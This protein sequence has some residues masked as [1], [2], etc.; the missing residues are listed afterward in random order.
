MT[1]PIPR[2]RRLLTLIPLIRRSPGIT[3]DQ[4]A[5]LLKVSRKEINADLVRLNLCGVPP[6]LP[7]DYISVLIDGD[8]ISIDYAE[9]FEKPAALTLREALALKLALEALPPG[10]ARINEARGELMAAVDRL[11]RE[12]GSEISLEL[13]G[14]LAQTT[15]DATTRKLTQLREAVKK[16]RPLDVV[17]YSASS[18]NTAPRRLRPLG[19]AESEGN[20]Y[21]VALDEGKGDLRHFRVDRIASIVEPKGAGAFEPPADFDLGAFM[22]KGFGPRAGKP[23]KLRFEKTVARFAKEDY[24]GF[25]M[26]QLPTGE[27]VVEIQ[28]G[29]VTWAVSRALSYG[30]HALVVSPPEARDELKK[31]LESFLE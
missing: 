12:Q 7:H 21:L 27:I 31:R 25:P 3:I 19:V 9:H 1:D 22:K 5:D 11:L 6:Y 8:H 20:H 14:R 24:D 30:E 28:A 23:I 10:D 29:S 4:L 2:L 17:Y 13:E 16:K 18:E 26:E 15:S